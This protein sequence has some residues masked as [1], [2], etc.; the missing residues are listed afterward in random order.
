[1]QSDFLRKVAAYR[2]DPVAN[3]DPKLILLGDYVDRGMFSFNGILRTVMQLF[4]SMPE[5]VYILRGNHEYYVDRHGYIDSGVRPAEGIATLAPFFPRQMFEAFMMLFD[6]MPHVLLFERMMFVHAGIPRDDSLEGWQD[7]SS[8]NDPAMRF[9]ML[10]SDPSSANFVPAELQR[11]NARFPFGK[12]QFRTFMQRIGCH[13]MLRGHEK[14]DEGCRKIYNEP[15]MTLINLFSA[16]GRENNDLPPGASYRSVNPMAL[17]IN[18]QDGPRGAYPW[19]IDWKSFNG[20][21]RNAFYR[22]PA[23]IEFR[24]F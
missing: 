16:G 13:T 12:Q 3:P 19:P 2:K 20:P 14:I 24:S 1:M 8:L 9:Q 23:E 7:L 11:E 10:W 18:W 15:D 21:E 4:V 6:S 22:S 5:H 17:T